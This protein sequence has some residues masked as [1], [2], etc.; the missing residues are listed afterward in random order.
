[1]KLNQGRKNGSYRVLSS[2]Y[3][4]GLTVYLLQKKQEKVGKKNI[5]NIFMGTFRKNNKKRP[6]F[7]QLFVD[8]ELKSIDGLVASGLIMF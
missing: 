7:V 1:M 6:I 8:I 2:I 5:L 3:T 4:S